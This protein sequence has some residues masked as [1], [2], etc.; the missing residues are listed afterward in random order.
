MASNQL[1]E[2]K[3]TLEELCKEVAGFIRSQLYLVSA[4]DIESKELNSLVSYVDKQAEDKI[5]SK[6]RSVTPDYGFITE[7]DT[8]DRTDKEKIWIIDPLDGTTNYL[9]KIPHFSISIALQDEGEVVLGIVYDIMLDTAYTAIKGFGAW[10]NERQMQV[11]ATRNMDQAIIVTGFP[12]KRN[13]NLDTSLDILKY[14]I[15]NSRGIRRLGSAALDLAYIA[16]GKLDIY[17]ES[18]LNIWDV[19][20]GALL[21]HE[22]GGIVTDYQGDNSYNKSGEILA[23]NKHLH[24]VMQKAIMNRLS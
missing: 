2:L 10:E 9:H 6:L 22:A 3:D 14:C 23:A 4:E 13:E 7:E 18:A 21:V 19:A 11:A 16:A 12:Y 24:P 8:D 15:L 5:V 17:Y 20:A 1:F